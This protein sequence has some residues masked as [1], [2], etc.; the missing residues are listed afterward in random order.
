MDNN[1]WTEEDNEQ[2]WELKIKPEPEEEVKR[3]PPKSPFPK[4]L[5]NIAWASLSSLAVKKSAQPTGDAP[6]NIPPAPPLPKEKSYVTSSRVFDEVLS[7]TN[8][9]QQRTKR[10]HAIFFFIVALHLIVTLSV[11]A[12][13]YKLSGVPVNEGRI[14]ILKNWE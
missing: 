5:G 10:K 12:T 1:I 7:A 3:P 8:S 11:I 13:V 4:R 2:E 6:I 9:E 14:L